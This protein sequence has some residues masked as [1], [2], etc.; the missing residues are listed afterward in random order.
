MAYSQNNRN[1]QI[2]T[3]DVSAGVALYSYAE[4]DRCITPCNN[5]P[6]LSNDPVAILCQ[7]NCVCMNNGARDTSDFDSISYHLAPSLTAWNTPVLYNGNFGSTKPISFLGFP[8]IKPNPSKPCSGFVLDSVT[9]DLCFT[10]TKQEIAILAIQFKEWRK[11]K[12]TGKMV[13]IGTTRRDIQIIV[14]ANCS[15][16]PPSIKGPFSQIVCSGEE[17]CFTDM[18]VNDPDTVKINNQSSQKDSVRVKWNN[19][20]PKAN[21]SKYWSGKN[22]YWNLCW[23]TTDA[24]APNNAPKTYFFNITAFDDA[25]P[26]YGQISRNFSITVKPS[27]GATRTYTNIGCGLYSLK[28]IPVK[29]YSSPPD[30]FW[31][32]DPPNG[33]KYN[34]QDTFHK[35]ST[36]GQHIVKHTIEL[37]GCSRT[38]YDTVDVPPFAEVHLPLDT[39]IC[40]GDS[41]KI[42][43][44]SVNAR[45]PYKFYWNNDTIARDS[46]YTTKSL[47]DTVLRV[48]IVDSTGCISDDSMI[49]NIKPLPIV[50]LGIDDRR[51]DGDSILFDGGDNNATNNV[52]KYTWIDSSDNSVLGSNRLYIEKNN[53]TIAIKVTDTIGCVSKDTVHAYFNPKVILKNNGPFQICSGDS[54]TIKIGTA[55][56]VFVSELTSGTLLSI[57]DTFRTTFYNSTDLVVYG[58]T[59]IGGVTCDAFDTIKITVYNPASA[60]VKFY[61]NRDWCPDDGVVRYYPTIYKDIKTNANVSANIYWLPNRDAAI[62]NAMDTVTGNSNRECLIDVGKLGST[63]AWGKL[64]SCKYLL[65]K[66]VTSYGCIYF[67][68]IELCVNPKPP[69][70]IPQKIF[71]YNMPPLKLNG[72]ATP[73]AGTL[74]PDGETWS[75]PGV[76]QVGGSNGDWYFNPSVGLGQYTIT[77]IFKDNQGYGCSD[78]DTVSFFVKPIP[79]IQKQNPLT[80]CNTD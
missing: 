23:Q 11:D 68:S 48:R 77:Y 32:V 7:G 17:A 15:N 13:V 72:L 42:T 49:I 5:S 63:Y 33:I 19:G 6:V 55:D 29:Q 50:D 57:E 66:V 16:K 25:C 64:K 12:K 61:P 9:G 35:F 22:E 74:S 80:F 4:I 44:Y 45:K 18:E 79:T 43:A 78:T 52:S 40:I 21:F 56:S 69:I 41:I 67:D 51:C 3:A 24:D 39:F 73:N 53:R 1:F 28:S 2:T 60:T 8:T 65:Y 54:L 36:A 70:K 30:Y 20:I 58:K 75:G 46:F 10:P 59:T 27:P 31:E 47:I 14:M 76:T 38:E 71:C 34:A 26:I 62:N 37:N